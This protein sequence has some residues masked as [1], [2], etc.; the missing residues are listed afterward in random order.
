M[1]QS[2]APRIS[3]TTPTVTDFDQWRV[4]YDV[5]PFEGHQAANAAWATMFPEQRSWNADACAQFLEETQPVRVLEVGGWDGA[6][7]GEM[8]ARFPKV[9]SWVNY[10]ITPNVPQTCDDRRY[11]RV[12]LNDWPWHTQVA[13]DVLIAS[14]VFEHMRLHQ[15]LE[16]VDAWTFQHLIMDVPVGP[17]A[18]N[19][20]G[21]AGSHIL[22][23]DSV[24]LLDALE[25][26]GFAVTHSQ[27]GLVA[28]LERPVGD[29]PF[30]P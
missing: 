13:G 25:A 23:V 19:W 14:H 9:V 6:L 21:Y 24:D 17:T 3:R 11:R 26:R 16:L 18:P 12:V 8:L 29:V 20:K 7:A 4:L 10:D 5:L 27:S 2:N 15:I 1:N 30:R 22:E 28:F